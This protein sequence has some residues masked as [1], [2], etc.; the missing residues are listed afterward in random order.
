MLEEQ[1][2]AARLFLEKDHRLCAVRWLNLSKCQLTEVPESLG[3][4]R[5]LEHLDLSN[6]K[7]RALPL[8]FL[9]LPRDTNV[10][11]KGGKLNLTAR[12][13][14]ACPHGRQMAFVA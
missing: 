5:N 8:S 12:E 13:S 2:L 3:L 6:N 14:G 1:I 10:L 4:A 9:K 7:L 11:L